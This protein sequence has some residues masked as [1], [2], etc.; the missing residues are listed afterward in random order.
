MHHSHP[1]LFVS[2]S[3]LVAVFGSWTALDLFSRVRSHIG[4]ARRIWLVGAAVVMGLS[5]WSMHFIAM[6]GFNP[7]GPVSYDPALTLLSLALAI[8]ATCGAF[9]AA[10][11]PSPTRTRMVLAG[12]A[13]GAGICLMHYVGMA[14]VRAAVSLAYR[15]GFVVASFVIAVTASTA[16]LFAKR[17]QAG[18]SW[19]AAAAVVLGFAIV[20][21]HYTAMA[22]LRLTP[23]AGTGPIAG[24]STFMLGVSIAAGTLVILFL[25]LLASLY[26]QRLNVLSSLDAG[27]VG[28]WELSLPDFALQ[29]SRRGR[30]IFGRDPDTPFARADFLS[31]LPPDELERS[32]RLLTAAIESGEEYDAEYRLELPGRD[33]WWINVRGQVVVRSGG[34]PRRMAGVVLDVTE[35]RRVVVALE[36]AEGRQRLLIDEL[37]HRVKNTLATVQS[38]ARQTA[39]GIVGGEDFLQ[40]YEARLVALSRTHDALTRGVWEKASL[41]DLLLQ[42][43]SPHA[44]E[45]YRL[46]GPDV[47][48]R[49]KQALALGMVFHELATNAAKHGALCQTQGCVQVN[50]RLERDVLEVTWRER[51]GPPVRP[52]SRRGFGSRLI[53]AALETELRGSADLEFAPDGLSCRLSVPLGADRKAEVAP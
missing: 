49:P 15:P 3:L 31:A 27:R 35:R 29:V 53:K 36:E 20:G 13:M 51:G 18:R 39:R 28:Y 12:V 19:R 16:A 14:A 4:A 30:Q 33:P 34:R 46:D 43:L 6:L 32:Q 42:E 8:G 1:T 23:V 52:P 7:G 2:L 22:G 50:W 5:I 11:G 41:S 47:S 25:G 21:M 10:G 17:R 38:I 40:A 37:Q 48:L 24:A 26:D 9:V 44:E 45:Q